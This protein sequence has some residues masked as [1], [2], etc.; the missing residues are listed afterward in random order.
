MGFGD[1]NQ[2]TTRDLS[3]LEQLGNSKFSSFTP[4]TPKL[5]QFIPTLG[6]QTDSHLLQKGL[7]TP[8]QDVN[9][10]ALNPE[11]KRGV[12]CARTYDMR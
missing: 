2:I 12:V 10:Q 4:E 11:R 8:N 3:P 6:P 5:L 9:W 1:N 7:G